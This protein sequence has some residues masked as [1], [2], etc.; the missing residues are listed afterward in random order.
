MG[1]QDYREAEQ[2]RSSVPG[3]WCGGGS[4]GSDRVLGGN[5]WTL[6]SR[7]EAPRLPGANRI[8]VVSLTV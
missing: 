8:D 6:Y 3:V 1:L 7:R 4:G 5:G 2:V